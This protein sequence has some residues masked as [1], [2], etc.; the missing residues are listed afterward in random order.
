MTFSCCFKPAVPLKSVSGN[1][2]QYIVSD[3]FYIQTAE[4]SLF[5]LVQDGHCLTDLQLQQDSH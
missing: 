2:S 4:N 5:V 3:V 1:I